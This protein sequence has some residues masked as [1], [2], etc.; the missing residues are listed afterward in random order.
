MTFRYQVFG[1]HLASDLELPEL[2]PTAHEAP[3]D[4][5]IRL[6]DLSTDFAA[7]HPIDDYQQIAPG[8]G[9]QFQIRDVAR[10]RVEASASGLIRIPMR[11]PVISGSGF[12][13]LPSARSCINGAVCPCMP[14][15]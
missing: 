10:Y 2:L 12:S 11:P 3:I 14:A 7:A 1:L 6:A 9:Y 5:D 8:G 15:R 13:A 4:I